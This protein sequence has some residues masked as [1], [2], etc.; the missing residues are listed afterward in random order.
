MG[1]LQENRRTWI[2]ATA[3]GA[4]WCCSFFSFGCLFLSLLLCSIPCTTMKN[5]ERA[6]ERRRRSPS[7]ESQASNLTHP[8]SSGFKTKRIKP[9]GDEPQDSSLVFLINSLSKEEG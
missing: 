5:N 1:E 3:A 8:S 7:G 4:G 6:K 9:F 2:A